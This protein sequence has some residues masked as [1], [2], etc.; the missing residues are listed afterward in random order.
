MAE[1][2]KPGLAVVVARVI[3][4]DAAFIPPEDVH[5]RPFNGRLHQS[6]VERDRCGAAA[7]RDEEAAAR[8]NRLPRGFFKEIGGGPAKLE[9][10]TEESHCGSPAARV[11]GTARATVLNR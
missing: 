11:D 4:R 3:D 7:Q 5:A 6:L 1:Q 10:I 8:R 9:M 2:H